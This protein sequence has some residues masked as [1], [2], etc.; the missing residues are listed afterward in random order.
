[1]LLID[2]EGTK[3]G[4]VSIREALAKAAEVGLDLV[5]VGP[6]AIPPV[7]KIMDYGQ[8][9]Y[10]EKKRSQEAKKKQAI[11]KVKEIK[12][13]PK[14]EPHDFEVKVKQI[15]QFLE[16]GCKVRVVIRFKG[17]EVVYADSSK[18]MLMSLFDSAKEFGHIEIQPVLSGYTMTMVI[19]PGV[20]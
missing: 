3:V 7:C 13:R 14:I 5:E 11:V 20:K 12:L 18:E 1:M 15:L 2:D 10:Q 8:L 16:E 9:K 6:N 17:R 4:A 19:A